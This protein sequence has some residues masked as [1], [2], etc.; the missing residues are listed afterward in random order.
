[1][2]T[3]NRLKNLYACSITVVVVNNKLGQVFSDSRGSL[4]QGGLSSME[5]FA[6]EIDPLL[7]FLEKRLE[8]I[9]IITIP[10]SGPVQQKEI[11]PIPPLQERFKLMAYCDDLKPSISSMS[12]FITV[13]NGC[14]IFEQASGCQ[15]HRDPTAGKCKFL[16]LGRWK[17]LLEQDGIPLPYM[18]LSD[19]LDMVL[20]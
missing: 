6:F 13:D 14:R 18:V 4:R 5:W 11:W 16:A 20:G 15:L 19:S 17:G 7:R 10:I 12:E 1:M 9:P 2:A 3:I 8:G